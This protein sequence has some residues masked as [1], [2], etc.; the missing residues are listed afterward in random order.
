MSKVIFIDV[1]GPLLPLRALLL[2]GQARGLVPVPPAGHRPCEQFDPVAVSML[3]RLCR[4]GPAKLVISSSWQAAAIPPLRLAGF[5]LVAHLHADPLTGDWDGVPRGHCIAGWLS[6]HPEVTHYV[7]FDD[8]ESI[9]GLSG[10]VLCTYENGLLVQHYY[11]AAALLEIC[12][13]SLFDLPI[14]ATEPKE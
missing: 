4:R 2:P 9:A 14:I 1:D 5:D 7:A 11:K 10:A 6:R 13:Q 3:D 8:D 12:R